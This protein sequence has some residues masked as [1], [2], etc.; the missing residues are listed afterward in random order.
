MRL[1]EEQHRRFRKSK[2]LPEKSD[3]HTFS[4]V[5]LEQLIRLECEIFGH[6]VQLESDGAL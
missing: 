6:E 2:G 1:T 4:E 5:E 3:P